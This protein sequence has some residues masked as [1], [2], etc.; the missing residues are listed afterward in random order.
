MYLFPEKIAPIFSNFGL[1]STTN[2]KIRS[3]VLHSTFGSIK[4]GI[5]PTECIVWN[6]YYG[7]YSS[8]I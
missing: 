1:K 6:V 3:L 8:E 2:G 5:I 4:L 7:M